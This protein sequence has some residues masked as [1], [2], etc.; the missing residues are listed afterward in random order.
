MVVT[1]RGL[2]AAL[3]GG[4]R[5]RRL[6]GGP[7]G[8]L[9]R[10]RAEG[11]HR[12]VH[13]LVA[14]SQESG[15]HVRPGDWRRCPWC[16]R[17]ST[18]RRAPWQPPA[19]SSTAAVCSPRWLWRC[20]GADRHTL[21]GHGRARGARGLQA[22]RRGRPGRRSGALRSEAAASCGPAT[23]IVRRCSSHANG[24]TPAEVQ[25]LRGRDRA[26]LGCIEG[27]IEEGICPGPGSAVGLAP[28]VPMVS[29]LL[30][31]IERGLP[32]GARPAGRG[33]AMQRLLGPGPRPAAC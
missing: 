10:P 32:G 24:A 28:D 21:R 12:R 22:R 6:Q 20:W 33:A 14:E 1:G 27:R 19:A 30:A 16:R 9:P 31:R 29:E 3:H 2:R 5:R 17:W 8:A 7:R 18:R 4:P 15:G 23:P 26:R 11:A 25:A 13:F